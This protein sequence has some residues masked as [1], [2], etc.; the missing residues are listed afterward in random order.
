MEILNEIDVIVK[1][2]PCISLIEA[3]QWFRALKTNVFN[4]EK[5]KIILITMD[6]KISSEIMQRVNGQIYP[7]S[8]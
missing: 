3:L 7:S 6:N 4:F 5:P 2:C 1:S 8:D